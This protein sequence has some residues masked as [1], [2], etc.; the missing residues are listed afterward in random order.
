MWIGAGLYELFECERPFLQGS[1]EEGTEDP[2]VCRS[3]QTALSVVQPCEIC[4]SPELSGL[5][6]RTNLDAVDVKIGESEMQAP[7]RMAASSI[8]R[9]DRR[10]FGAAQ[11]RLESGDFACRSGTFGLAGTLFRV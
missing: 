1:A 7:G 9:I 11:N 6:P 4:R 3:I 5:T 8:L 2:H 10:K